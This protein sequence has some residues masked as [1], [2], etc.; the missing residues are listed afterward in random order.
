MQRL[1]V[2]K[3]RL[4]MAGAILPASPVVEGWPGV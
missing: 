3:L 2:G 1:R 4:L